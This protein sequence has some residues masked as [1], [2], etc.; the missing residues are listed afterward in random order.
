MEE[1]PFPQCLLYKVSIHN[2]LVIHNIL[3]KDSPS[4]QKSSGDFTIPTAIHSFYNE[5]PFVNVSVSS[6]NLPW[7]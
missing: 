1:V 4:P 2:F 6:T 3:L 7:R 5:L